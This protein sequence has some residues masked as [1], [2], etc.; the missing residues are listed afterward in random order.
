LRFLTDVRLANS[1]T[2]GRSARRRAA[3]TPPGCVLGRGRNVSWKAFQ[4]VNRHGY[5]SS[6]REPVRAATSCLG[7]NRLPRS[8]GGITQ[9]ANHQDRL[10]IVRLPPGGDERLDPLPKLVFAAD[11]GFPDS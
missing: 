9:V 10:I 4:N 8:G 1:Q 7:S 2:S 3:A 11:E 5:I 6:M